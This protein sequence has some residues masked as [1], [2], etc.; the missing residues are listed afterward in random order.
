MVTRRQIGW[1]LLMLP[2]LFGLARAEGAMDVDISPSLKVVGLYSL[3]ADKA[4]YSRF[5]E[6]Q[7]AF[8][9]PA[10]FSEEDKALF[11]RLG[12]G[13]SLH[14]FTD[15]DRKEREDHLRYHMD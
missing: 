5:I 9:D 1:S 3:S 12:R 7:I 4:S 11:R 6:Q 10:N 13:D 14:P 8:H 15:D 2:M